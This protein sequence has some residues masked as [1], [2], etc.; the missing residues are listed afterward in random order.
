MVNVILIAS[1]LCV[2]GGWAAAEALLGSLPD[3]VTVPWIC[4]GTL[5]LLAGFVAGL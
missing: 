3:K 2:L 4:A 1:G 5:L